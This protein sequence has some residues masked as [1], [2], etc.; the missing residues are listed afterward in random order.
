MDHQ[1]ETTVV[2]FFSTKKYTLKGL[3]SQPWFQP[4]FC[5]VLAL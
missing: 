5:Q 3:Q 2:E 4:W 1:V